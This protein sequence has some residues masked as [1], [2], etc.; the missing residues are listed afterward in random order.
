MKRKGINENITFSMCT[1]LNFKIP[2]YLMYLSLQVTVIRKRCFK[3]IF[4][5]IYIH[6]SLS[7]TLANKDILR[8]SK[9]F[10]HFTLKEKKT[11][12]S[13]A[14]FEALRS[15]V[16]IDNQLSLPAEMCPSPQTNV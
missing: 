3:I 15:A 14:D 1:Y 11:I 5:C 2:A 8:V 16:V 6:I 10:L 9:M 13:S 12:R 4:V 7:K